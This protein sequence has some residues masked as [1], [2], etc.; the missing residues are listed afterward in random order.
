MFDFPEMD[1]NSP[2]NL[3]INP[4]STQLTDSLDVPDLLTSTPAP[5]NQL[6]AIEVENWQLSLEY[7]PIDVDS[8]LVPQSIEVEKASTS[9]ST[10]ELDNISK[11]LL[12]GQILSSGIG[13]LN[14]VRPYTIK[15]GDTLWNIAQQELGNPYN[16]V[17]IQKEDG[18]TFTEA[19]ARNLQIGQLVYLPMSNSPFE[20]DQILDSVEPSMLPYAQDSIP[21]ILSQVEQSG[22]TDQ[23][24]IAYILATAEHESHL[25]RWMEELSDGWQYEGR[26]DLG[27][28]HPG[29]GPRFKG[30][31]Y[32]QI[33]GRSNYQYW[34]N[35]L[36]IDL[37]NNPQRA[38]EPE[39][40]ATI[41][42]QGM[43]DGT[44]TGVS[45]NDY[46]N[47]S[48]LDFYNARRIVNRL[49]RAS[50]IAAIAEDYLR[51]LT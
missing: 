16:W 8:L 42:V 12:T 14:R 43:R 1:A 19:E 40:A 50:E 45:L 34:S 11:D 26:Q 51:I 6:G 27:N 9:N 21:L 48:Q 32:I 44:F 5:N 38:S 35:I 13:T 3:S 31:G 2:L 36:G 17:N 41:L 7:S 20:L 15:P 30:R 28:I 24:Q 22:I 18:T 49:D 33:T 37:V 23:A 47:N 4:N 29:D 39:I 25:G 46:I 10:T